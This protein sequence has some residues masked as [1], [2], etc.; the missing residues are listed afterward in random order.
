MTASLQGSPEAI[1]TIAPFNNLSSEGQ[2]RLKG[3]ATLVRFR[4]GEM[5]SPGDSV[6]DRVLV[7]LEGEARLLGER[8]GRPFTLERL[9][10]G[11]IIGLASLL[12]AEGCEPVSA[13]TELLVAA[14]PDGV[15]LEL[16]Q[17]EPGLRSWCATQVWTAELHDLLHRR[18]SSHAGAPSFD[19]NR[20]RG[21]LERLR[22]AVR[23]VDAPSG[24]K[25]VELAADEH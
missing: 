5:V 1:A 20:W 13:A 17:S 2:L 6:G 18:D 15:M 25:K 23:A 8:D 7:V 4:E 21:R 3:S 14:I 12:R 19:P 24:A 16:L 22:A 9:R 11:A 10:S